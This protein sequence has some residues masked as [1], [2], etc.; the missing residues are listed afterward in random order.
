MSHDSLL[1]S[2]RSAGKT[3][4]RVQ[5]EF[6]WPGIHNHCVRYTAS[7]DLCQRNASKGSVAKAPLGKMPL[8][9]TPF[10]T[11]CVELVGPINPPSGGYTLC[12]NKTS[13]FL[14]FK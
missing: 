8:I 6:Y 5:S 13:T 2:H 7:C 14:F 10:S 12:P 9:G 11:V 4:A 1:A 3:Y